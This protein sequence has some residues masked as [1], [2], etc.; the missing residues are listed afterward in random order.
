AW[1]EPALIGATVQRSTALA[2]GA[3]PLDSAAASDGAMVP[4]DGAVTPNSAVVSDKDGEPASPPATLRSPGSAA[5][6]RV[7]GRPVAE[8]STPED[9][10]QGDDSRQSSTTDV[11]ARYALTYQPDSSPANHAGA[12]VSPGVAE[13]GE[14]EPPIAHSDL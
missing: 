7:G 13:A 12:D 6:K 8:A 9:G 11:E 1:P 4:T 3:L 5:K 10:L 2:D 14:T